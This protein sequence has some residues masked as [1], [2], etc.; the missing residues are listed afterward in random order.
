MKNS[1]NIENQTVVV[2]HK[3]R[4]KDTAQHVKGEENPCR[5]FTTTF[6]FSEC[7]PEEILNLATKSCTIAYR[8]KCKVNEITEDKF[9]ELMKNPINVHTELKAERKGMSADE[10]VEKIYE[11]MTEQERADLIKK[12][13]N[14]R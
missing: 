8:T 2:K 12:L 4:C 14:K 3:T 5:E 11:T 13:T 6:D 9:A 1:I 7:T 10:K